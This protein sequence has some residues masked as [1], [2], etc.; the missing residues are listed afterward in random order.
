MILYMLNRLDCQLTNTQLSSFFIENSYTDYFTIQQELSELV[1]S[2]F[3]EKVVI[4]NTSYYSI[5][6]EGY[7]SLTLFKNQIPRT[8]IEDVNTFLEAHK[9]AL[10]DE[11]GTQSDYYK[12]TNGDYIAHCKVSEGKSLL[13]ELSISVPSEEEA[14]RVCQN[15]RGYSEDIYSFIMK[16]LLQ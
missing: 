1:V 8:A 16:N 3:V 15:F 14:K 7:T 11:V 6:S 10:K 13:Y 12:H 9:Y 2:G 4:R 5:T